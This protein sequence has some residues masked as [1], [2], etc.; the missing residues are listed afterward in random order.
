MDVNEQVLDE[1]LLGAAYYAALFCL[2]PGLALI[3][4]DLGPRGFAS[5]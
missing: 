4:H 2:N 3:A 5:Y 1:S